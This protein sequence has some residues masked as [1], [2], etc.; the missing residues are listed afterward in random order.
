MSIERDARWAE[1][2]SLGV[3]E[4]RKRLGAQQYGEEKI[5]LAR[6]WL[7]HQESLRTSTDNAASLA[8]A[9]AANDLAK[10]ANL[11]ASEANVIARAASDSAKR[12]AA[13]ARTNN[14]IA[15]AALIAAV[16]AIVVSIIGL[17]HP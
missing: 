12:S 1:F 16:I 3:E 7:A 2:E 6:E 14:I 11:S 13:A 5:R 4:I 9:R 15:T 10:A 8:E 17:K